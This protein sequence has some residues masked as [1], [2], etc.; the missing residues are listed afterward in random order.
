MRHKYFWP[1]AVTIGLVF[2]LPMPTQA[3]ATAALPSAPPVTTPQAQPQSLGTVHD[4]TDCKLIR[5]DVDRLLRAGQTTA[6]CVEPVSLDGIDVEAAVGAGTDAIALP[7]WCIDRAFTGWWF[8]RFSSCMIRSLRL[9]VID[10]RTGAIVGVMDFLEVNYSYMSNS[11]IN[12]AQQVELRQISAT[13]FAIGTFAQGSAGCSGS[14]IV[15][16]S[17]FP[18]QPMRTN[19][20]AEGDGFFNT[21]ISAPGGVGFATT[22]WSYFFTNTSW[23]APSPPVVVGP[24]RVRCDNA[25]AG[26]PFVGCVHPDYWSV[27]I[28]SLAGAAPNYARHI[29]DAQA[30][31]LRGAYPNGPPLTRLT[32]PALSAQNGNTACPPAFPRP[33]GHS[34]DEY[35][36][37][38][39]WEGA[40]TGGGSGRTHPW[41]QLPALGPGSG[42]TGWSSCMIPAG[43]NSSGGGSLGAFYRSDRVIERDPFYVWVV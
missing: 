35:P 33:A 41:C 7:Q 23:V 3:A 31:G 25:T 36:Y 13:G 17:T 22:S 8:M 9:N 42:P 14:C 39:T 12:W 16:Q 32:D 20:D 30:S 10:V 11:T 43:E 5:H 2:A 15:S 38:S 28:V 4:Q 40:F 26:A 37:R 34:C 27:H 19:G 1:I 21:T 24:P 18:S 29:R 6:T